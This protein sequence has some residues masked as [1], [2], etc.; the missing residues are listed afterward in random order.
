MSELTDYVIVAGTELPGDDNPSNDDTSAEVSNFLCQPE[1][2][3]TLGDGL[4]LVSVE[5]INNSSGCETDGYGDFTDL[6]ANLAQGGTYDITLS[7]GYGG[8]YVKVWVD[9]NDDFTFS[10][11]EVI[12]NN[13]IIAPG[14]AAGNYTETASMAI[15]ANAT[16]G[17]HRM[18]IKTNWN[19]NV[20][21]DACEETT[22]GETEDYTAN[23]TD[24][25]G[26]NESFYDADFV[27]SSQDQNYF[28]LNFKSSSYT[29]DLPVYVIN[30]LGQTLAYYLLEYNGTGF[31]KT[32]NMSYVSSGV[33]FIKIGSETLNKVQRII[34]K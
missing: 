29:N 17:L 1:I 10:N 27:I 6:I 28:D 30:T 14:E 19:A 34:V 8:Q 31:S 24:E 5:E 7:T 3:C 11:N 2:N 32:I 20:P 21:V 33:Y 26:L 15:P 16:L 9:Y 13:F 22:Y 25:L 18:R 4:T 12:L 23:I